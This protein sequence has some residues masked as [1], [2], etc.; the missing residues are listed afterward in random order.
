MK[1]KTPNQQQ[2]SFPSDNAPKKCPFV[3]AMEEG[4]REIEKT[5]AFYDFIKEPFKRKFGINFDHT[6]IFLYSHLQKK[7]LRDQKILFTNKK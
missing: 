1:N 2:I 5:F 7:W 4:N 6:I 3:E